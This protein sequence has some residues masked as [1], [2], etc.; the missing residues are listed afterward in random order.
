MVCDIWF[1]QV[2]YTLKSIW[3]NLNQNR[4]GAQHMAP[5]DSSVLVR[6]DQGRGALDL[7]RN[8]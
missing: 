7:K 1:F 3:K 8:M 6:V 5:Y 2:S 4:L